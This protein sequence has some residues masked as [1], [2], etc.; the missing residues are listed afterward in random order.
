MSV[1]LMQQSSKEK[2]ESF[3]RWYIG[4]LFTNPL[5]FIISIVS[6]CIANGTNIM[7][8]M[9]IGQL[10]DLLISNI[11]DISVSI[12]LLDE[13]ILTIIILFLMRLISG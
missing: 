9:L 13:Y 4:H 1:T 10:I 6:I 7:V 3:R 2:K 12:S 11:G 8:L 5:I